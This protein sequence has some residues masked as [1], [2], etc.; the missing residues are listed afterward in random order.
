MFATVRQAGLRGFIFPSA[1]LAVLFLALL[2]AASLRSAQNPT[3]PKSGE[4]APTSSEARAV[5]N[6]PALNT[7]GQ[8]G[9]ATKSNLEKA[10]ADAAELSALADQLRD[11]VNKSNANVLSLDIIRKTEKLEKL[12]RKIKGEAIGD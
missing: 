10:R 9:E 7:G 11:A 5:K 12:A 1:S 2:V 3:P 8:K 6:Q 4:A